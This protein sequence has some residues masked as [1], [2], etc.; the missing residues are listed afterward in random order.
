M[1]FFLDLSESLLKLAEDKIEADWILHISVPIRV[2]NFGL[3]LERMLNLQLTRRLN[4][5][6]DYKFSNKTARRY[7]KR[8][9]MSMHQIDESVE[10]IQQTVPKAKTENIY[11]NESD[12]ENVL[13]DIKYKVEDRRDST[14][15]QY[16]Y[17]GINRALALL[18]KEKKDKD[19]DETSKMSQEE[20]SS[21]YNSFMSNKFNQ[22]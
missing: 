4:I 16:V 13:K 21:L 22:S 17:G 5:D 9:L 2:I 12:I 20:T 19:G 15:S 14:V 10:E 3:I 18:M 1:S 6:G 8:T 11:D 7:R